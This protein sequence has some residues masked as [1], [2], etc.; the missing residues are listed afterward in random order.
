MKTS[1][2]RLPGNVETSASSKKR[3][4]WPKSTSKPPAKTAVDTKQDIEIAKLKKL[5]KANLPPVKSTY[6]EG[7]GN[8]E[9]SF[10]AFGM[11]WPQKGGD[12]NERLNQ[13]IVLKSINIRYCVNVSESDNFDTMRVVIVQ[14]MDGNEATA[15]PLNYATN[16][17]LSPVTDFPNLS[18]FNT[19]SA[20]SYHVLYDKIHN[21][22]D[23]GVSQENVN[24]LLRPKD[25]R[26]TKF[27]FDT[28]AGGSFPAFDRGLIVM[29]VCS[30]SSASPQPKD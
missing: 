12:N 27:K 13:E 3:K 26:I 6:A 20:S 28:D 14:F 19:Q 29:F 25:F 8:P 2:S 18:P 1:T 15:F 16:L 21:L 22:N 5:M 11:P 30:D 10:V 4:I 9:N 17:W 24:L 23:N 7:T